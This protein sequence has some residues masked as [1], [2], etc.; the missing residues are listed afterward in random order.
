MLRPSGPQAGRAQHVRGDPFE[1][2]PPTIPRETLQMYFYK[3]RPVNGSPPTGRHQ[4]ETIRSVCAPVGGSVRTTVPI[5][6]PRRS[7]AR[8]PAAGIGGALVAELPRSSEGARGYFSRPQFL[9]P[10]TSRTLI[11]SVRVAR[12]A[13]R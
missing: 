7:L 4:I 3:T 10:L 5:P 1:I 8:P 12:G 9:R 13:G 11:A 6:V 2:P